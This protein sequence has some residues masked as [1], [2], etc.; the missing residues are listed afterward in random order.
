MTTTAGEPGTLRVALGEYDIGWHDPERSL[1]R[2]DAVV[3]AAARAGAALV[4]LPEMC[5]TGFTMDVS[6][7]PRGLD[8]PQVT[9]LAAIARA[10]SVHLIAGVGLHEPSLDSSS[11]SGRSTESGES[12]GDSYS[13]SALVFGPDGAL[14]AHYRKQRLFAFAGED[15]SYRA[16]GEP[17]VVEINGVRIAPLICF[18]LRFPELFQAVASDVDACIVIA[19]WPHTRR[20]HW[21]TLTRARAIESQCYVV[22]VNRVGEAD[23]LTYDGGSAAFDAMGER[24]DSLT[25]D[26]RIAEVSSANVRAVRARF[27]FYAGRA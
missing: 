22:A 5:T 26:V 8:D 15:D 3:R 21:D 1:A 13:N 6:V 10:H 16:G 14:L 4:A 24:V 25:S 7:Q 18:D 2:A 20:T 12:R 19:N 27:P 9:G 17:V 23:G 11:R